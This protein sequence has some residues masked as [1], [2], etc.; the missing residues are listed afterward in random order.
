MNQTSKSL[1][2]DWYNAG[3]KKEAGLEELKL[4]REAIDKIL[5]EN[6][7]DFWLN[8]AQVY[9]GLSDE[10]SEAFQ[11]IASR[12]KSVDDL[13]PLK[14]VNLLRVLSG[15]LIAEKMEINDNLSCD[16]LSL[17]IIINSDKG[18]NIIPELSDRAKKFYIRECESKRV[19]SIT[20]NSIL[21]KAT[22]AKPVMPTMSDHTGIP[23]FVK[24]LTVYLNSTTKDV[25][26]LITAANTL[27]TTQNT[28]IKKAYDALSE[29][30]NILWW[31]FSESSDIL[32]KS[33]SAIPMNLLTI[34]VALELQKLTTIIP[35][36]GKVSSIIRKALS[37]VGDPN[38]LSTIEEF[39]VSTKEVQETIGKN[40]ITQRPTAKAL[41]PLTSALLAYVQF[42]ESEWKVVLQKALGLDTTN[43]LSAIDFAKQLYFE[44]MLL[45]ICNN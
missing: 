43:T 17:A 42:S 26:Q 23:D 13:F 32:E 8:I 2:T 31:L 18:D 6:T 38:Q 37:N 36:A 40:L 30:T 41:T 19:A 29:E 4:R 12:F 35:G 39:V 15:C 45:R 20:T 44:S 3:L 9:L 21:L 1:F 10:N 33:M 25:A 16:V 34:I 14:N 11:D 5:K 7:Y 27:A 28:Q 24:Q 22:T